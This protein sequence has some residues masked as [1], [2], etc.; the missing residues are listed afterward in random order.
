MVG[1]RYRGRRPGVRAA[2]YIATVAAVRC[3]P[4]V[5]A[6]HQ[7]L[8]GRGKPAKV[9]LTAYMRKLVVIFNALLREQALWRYA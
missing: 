4:P 5:A 8:R 2:L 3:N 6:A 9:A 1:A 7:R